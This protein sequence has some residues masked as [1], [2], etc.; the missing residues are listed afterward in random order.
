M[1]KYKLNFLTILL[2]IPMFAIGQ[3][4]KG[5]F[6]DADDSAEKGYKLKPFKQKKEGIYHYAILTELPFENDCENGISEKEQIA[7]AEKNL[8]GLINEKL[9]SETEFNGN[10]YVYLTVTE[11]AEIIDIK[12][13]S[14]PQSDEID[15][16]I[17]QA[18]EQIKV[19]PAKYK[20]KVVTS[21][22]WTKLEFNSNEND[23]GKFI[24]KWIGEDE[25]D[26]G[27]L[28]FDSEGYAY[29]EIQGQIMGGKE[30]VQNG[31]KGSMTY[32]INSETKP[33]QVD[34]IVTMFETKK[35]KKLL[36]I[37]NFIDDDTME[38]AIGFEGIRPTEFDSE[39]SIILKRDK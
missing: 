16:L 34:L 2:L 32:E 1:S 4:P 29:F 18:T 28:N 25:K 39:D 31:K 13:K 19:R 21:R 6:L 27:Y 38:F 36:C 23:K 35:Q 3:I 11:K 5:H 24:G 33:I 8:N 12:V 9:N 15:K 10:V 26:I 20:K 17:K 22:L 14:Y 7:C 30:F 37:S